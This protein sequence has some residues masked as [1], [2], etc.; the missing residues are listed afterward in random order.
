MENEGKQIE[1]NLKTNIENV[2]KIYFKEFLNKFDS[3]KFL[4]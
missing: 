1:E 3:K 2:I 4:E